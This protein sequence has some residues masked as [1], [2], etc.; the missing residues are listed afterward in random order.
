MKEAFKQL[1]ITSLREK[2]NSAFDKKSKDDRFK[3]N[4][5]VL[6]QLENKILTYWLDEIQ[7]LNM[8]LLKSE[9]LHKIS[10]FRGRNQVGIYLELRVTEPKQDFFFWIEE[11][12]SSFWIRTSVPKRAELTYYSHDLYSFRVGVDENGHPIP[13]DSSIDETFDLITQS[14]IKYLGSK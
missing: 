3:A 5:T 11:V 4:Q 7:C 14:M 6:G 9:E 8:Q 13:F 10:N 2:T 1:K 12:D